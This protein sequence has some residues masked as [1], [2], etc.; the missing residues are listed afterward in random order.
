MSDA[1]RTDS[2]T[3][4]QPSSLPLNEWKLAWCPSCE[5]DVMPWLDLNDARETQTRCVHCDQEL[6]PN[7]LRA[8]SS[9]E[10]DEIG[11]QLTP[12]DRGCGGCGDG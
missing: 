7:S 4:N 3:P 1:K 11:Y 12:P 8:S 9:G 5:R 6:D 2:Q 10:L